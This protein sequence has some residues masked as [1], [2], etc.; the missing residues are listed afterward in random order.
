MN[1]G[2]TCA[3]AGG[4]KKMVSTSCGNFEFEKQRLKLLRHMVTEGGGGEGAGGGG[5]DDGNPNNN[6]N[7][8]LL[9]KSLFC[10][11]G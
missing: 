9:K 10:F 1:D 4:G 8:K 2:P 7:K 3:I 11:V 6:Y 5:H